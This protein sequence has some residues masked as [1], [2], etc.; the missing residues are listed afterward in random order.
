MV[1][2]GPHNSLVGTLSVDGDVRIEGRL[3][4]EVSATGEVAVHSSGTVRAQIAARDIVVAG[5]VEGNAVAR[6]LTALTETASFAGEIHTGRLRVDE[7]ATVNATISMT[8]SGDA[9]PARRME[10]HDDEASVDVTGSPVSEGDHGADGNAG[11]DTDAYSDERAAETSGVSSGS[12]L[13]R[14]LSQGTGRGAAP[15][16]G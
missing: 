7:G 4:G 10:E 15:W 9:P 2:L 11:S 13:R 1:V 5:S 3:E 14:G 12:D 16:R 6:E 8:P